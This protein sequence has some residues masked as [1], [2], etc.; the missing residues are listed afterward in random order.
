MLSADFP[1]RGI[2]RY[3][4]EVWSKEREDGT[5]LLSEVLESVL[6]KTSNFPIY[7]IGLY[8]GGY[9]NEVSK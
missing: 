3:Y 7:N 5:T 2:V 1:K 9:E 8:L 4:Y 6:K